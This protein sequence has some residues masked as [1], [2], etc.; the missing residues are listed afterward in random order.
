MQAKYADDKPSDCSVCDFWRNDRTGCSL[1]QDSCYYLI[2][3]PPRPE[4]EC[5]GCPY[6]Q[7]HPCI[8]WCTKKAMR[9]VGIK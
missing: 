5:D 6:G 7:A 1:G 8:G 4:N 9:E 2:A 3:V